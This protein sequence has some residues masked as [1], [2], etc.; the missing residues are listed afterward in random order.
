MISL[1]RTTSPSIRA[2]HA[3]VGDGCLSSNRLDTQPEIGALL[4]W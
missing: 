3:M 4:P 2:R 1:H